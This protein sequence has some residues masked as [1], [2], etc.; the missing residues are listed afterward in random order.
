MRDMTDESHAPGA[1]QKSGARATPA[2]VAECKATG[3]RISLR[4][5]HE[6]AGIATEWS[7]LG[8]R[9]LTPNV[10]YEP[11]YA[12]PA[13]IPF[14]D[15]VQLLAVHADKTD[16]GPLLGA[17]PF[18]VV[19]M[20]WGVPLPL[21]HGWTHPFAATGVPLVDKDRA[22]DALTALLSAPAAFGLPRRSLMPL[23]PDE[24]AFAG[25]LAT[26][27]QKLGLRETRTEGHDRAMFTPR[28][29]ED[30]QA[31]L[32]SGS[33]SKLR[34]EYRRLEKD[35]PV[36]L[37]VAETPED[38][39]RALDTY[40]ELEAKGW[41]GRAGTAIPNSHGEV[42]FMRGSVRNLAAQGRVRI[43]ELKLGE[44]VI[45]SSITYRNGGTAWYAKISFDEEF[46]KN[47]PGSQLVLKVTEAMNA[48]PEL[49]FVDSCAPP[50]HPLMRRF[51]PE[52][53]NVSHRMLELGGKDMFFP[54]AVKL[55]EQRPKAREFYHKARGWLN[56]KR[57]AG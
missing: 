52:R 10:F 41:K 4:P 8:M 50:L 46:S 42:E 31:H 51:W 47:S 33:R 38:T 54:L 15:G 40:L 53:M 56:S 21:I 24:C 9:A 5:L 36:T 35:G 27:Q 34:Q 13:G 11:E 3:L 32:S 6:S 2:R 37:S 39:A 44:R 48:D 17:W 19:R 20:R 30:T 12:V 18:R 45:A 57:K 29:A 22:Q 7:A 1:V 28:L 23:V 26:V 43:D 14:G 16:G 25:V 49:S 55:E